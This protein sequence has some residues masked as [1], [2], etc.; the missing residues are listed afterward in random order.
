MGEW[1]PRFPHQY[2]ATVVNIVFVVIDSPN[3]DWTVTGI[4]NATIQKFGAIND[5]S[6]KRGD[7]RTPLEYAD[8][9]NGSSVRYASGQV[10]IGQHVRYETA[11]LSGKWKSKVLSLWAR[12]L[13]PLEKPKNICD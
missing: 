12:P 4:N 5:E 8:G 11:P 13:P 3:A 2:A 1:G 9:K 10:H 6:K 7:A